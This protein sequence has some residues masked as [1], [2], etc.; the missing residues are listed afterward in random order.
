MSAIP[1]RKRALSST[2]RT[3]SDTIFPILRGVPA[4]RT[5]P[6]RHAILSHG[7]PVSRLPIISLRDAQQ[8]GRYRRL[9]SSRQEPPPALSAGRDLRRAAG[10]WVQASRQPLRL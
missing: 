8:D 10:S 2:S 4:W 7:T 6:T 9:R 1:A 3:L 5:D